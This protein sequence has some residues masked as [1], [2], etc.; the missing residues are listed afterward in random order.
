MDD[1]LSPRR[2]GRLSEDD[3]PSER[4]SALQT[5][6]RS[7]RSMPSKGESTA[8]SNLCFIMS[9]AAP[10]LLAKD[11]L[12]L[13]L[14]S[15]AV[16]Q[17][18]R[19]GA[20]RTLKLDLKNC[21][22]EV[23]QHNMQILAKEFPHAREMIITG[24]RKQCFVGLGECLH[25]PIARLSVTLTDAE[26]Q[27]MDGHLG[28]NLLATA[29][30]RF[31][32]LERL[33]VRNLGPV[34]QSAFK[35][36]CSIESL[37]MIRLIRCPTL[38]DFSLTQI[39]LN[40]PHLQEITLEECPSL[41]API[42]VSESLARLR[43][44]QCI[45]LRDVFIQSCPSLL[46]L[47]ISYTFLSK[48]PSLTNAPNLKFISLVGTAG[49]QSLETDCL[50]E[51][52]YS[53]DLTACTNLKSVYLSPCHHLVKL[54]LSCC[55]SL[56]CLILSQA[57]RLETLNLMLLHRLKLVRIE[58]GLRMKHIVLF[59]CDSLTSDNVFVSSTCKRYS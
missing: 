14:T 30:A 17:R 13:S 54:N 3:G 57:R 29:I 49:L 23:V 12:A 28:G 56:E 40:A 52:L 48:L 25:L 22:A 21:N 33:E 18:L 38:M 45:A 20:V 47:D 37:R 51:A 27:L 26:G 4:R 11:L 41:R 43:L 55:L 39:I 15:S 10:Y 32:R 9:L 34:A 58:E 7:R 50:P 2:T 1:L 44:S 36:M 59:G 42:I 35:I 16:R 6:G 31:S 46:I 19:N 5:R 53:L 24:T 8:V